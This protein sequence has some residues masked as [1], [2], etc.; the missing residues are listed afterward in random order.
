VE[1]ERVRPPT[2]SPVG[3]R[4][5]VIIRS[6]SEEMSDWLRRHTAVSERY[7]PDLGHEITDEVLLDA[8][9]FITDRRGG[10]RTAPSRKRST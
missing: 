8:V 6:E 10:R 4:D 7:Y 2:C 9:T 3:G 1:L 5:D